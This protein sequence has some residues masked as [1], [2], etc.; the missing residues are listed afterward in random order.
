M[1]FCPKYIESGCTMLNNFVH[2]WLTP[3]KKSG[4]VWSALSFS[5][6]DVGNVWVHK[7]SWN[8][9]MTSWGTSR[10][11]PTAAAQHHHN[12]IGGMTWGSAAAQHS[13]DGRRETGVLPLPTHCTA[14]ATYFKRHHFFVC[15]F[16]SKNTF[17]SFLF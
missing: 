4:L 5:N 14:L 12:Q 15:L 11:P 10:P 3:L 16:K 9:F 2:I 8:T 7:R 17:H 1:Y 13:R 6:V